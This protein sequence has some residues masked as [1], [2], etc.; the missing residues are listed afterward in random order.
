MDRYRVEELIGPAKEV[1]DETFGR[2]ASIKKII[3]SKMS[4]FGAA[5]QMSGVLPAVALYE[6]QEKS[7]DR[8]VIELIEKLYKRMYPGKSGTLFYMVKDEIR[9]RHEMAVTD[10]VLCASIALKL[11]LN[12]FK[13]IEDND[14]GGNA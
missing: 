12:L 2:N 10:D 13:L 8:K 4:A 7:E 11:A 5:I 3:R 6:D 14:A 9:E 1:I